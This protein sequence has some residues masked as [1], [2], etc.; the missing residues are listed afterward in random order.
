MRT[1]RLLGLVV[2]T[3]LFLPIL[4]TLLAG[5]DCTFDQENKDQFFGEFALKQIQCM[6]SEHLPI[7]S[8]GIIMSVMLLAIS[9]PF[10]LLHFEH[11]PL[12][13]TPTAKTNGRISFIFCL[14]KCVL[15]VLWKF[16]YNHGV[17]EHGS[18]NAIITTGYT[19]LMS[20]TMA[21]MMIKT[22]P[23][24]QAS[25][26]HSRFSIYFTATL[27]NLGAFVYSIASFFSSASDAKPLCIYLMASFVP[28]FVI[29][30][31]VSALV[32]KRIAKNVEK[33]YESFAAL[34]ESNG[35]QLKA[36]VYDNW[37]DVEIVGRSLTK[38]TRDRLT[39]IDFSAD[40]D[41]FNTRFDRGIKEWPDNHLVL[42]AYGLYL[43]H[44]NDFEFRESLKTSPKA[45]Q[46]L[47]LLIQTVVRKLKHLKRNKPY[48]DVQFV[49]VYLDRLMA[50]H[51]LSSSNSEDSKMDV[52]AYAEFK[53]KEKQAFSCHKMAISNINQAWSLIASKDYSNTQL[54]KVCT[55]LYN[56]TEIANRAYSELVRKFPSN[57]KL[58]KGYARFLIQVGHQPY[59][60]KNLVLQINAMEEATR[61]DE[62]AFIAKM[63]KKGGASTNGNNKVIQRT[64][65]FQSEG[66]GSGGD[67]KSDV[68]GS[69][70]NATSVELAQENMLKGVKSRITDKLRK[71]LR[72]LDLNNILISVVAMGTISLNFALVAALIYRITIDITYFQELHGREYYISDEVYSARKMYQALK[73]N[74]SVSY[75]FYR[76]R[77][78]SAFDSLAEINEFLLAERDKKDLEYSQEYLERIYNITIALYPASEEN[79]IVM[80]SL[81]DFVDMYLASGLVFVNFDYNEY[82]QKRPWNWL[83]TN[84]NF[85]Y[86]MDNFHSAGDLFEHSKNVFIAGASK[87]SS[88]GADT[89][90]I[91]LTVLQLAVVLL[92]LFV[93]DYIVSKFHKKQDQSLSLMRFIPH[94]QVKEITEQFEN[95]GMNDGDSDD[96]DDAA[97]NALDMAENQEL[98][99]FEGRN[100]YRLRYSI[101]FAIL[102]SLSAAT[103]V[104]NKTAIRYLGQKLAV[105]DTYGDAK[106]SGSRTV[107]VLE[108]YLEND[109]KVWGNEENIRVYLRQMITHM[110]NIKEH[111]VQGDQSFDP[112]GYGYVDQTDDIK[113]ITNQPNCLPMNE[114]MCQDL[115]R[116]NSTV[117]FD[118]EMVGAG[119]EALFAQVMNR[120]V[121]IKEQAKVTFKPD[122]LVVQFL[123]MV[124]KYDYPDGFDKVA[125]LLMVTALEHS[126]STQTTEIVFLV[127]TLSFIS[128]SYFIVFVLMAYELRQQLQQVA[129]LFLF[130][131]QTV[132]KAVPELSA[133]VQTGEIDAETEKKIQLIATR[134]SGM[135][136]RAEI[137]AAKQDAKADADQPKAAQGGFFKNVF[138]SSTSKSDDKKPIKENAQIE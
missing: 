62:D 125:K 35:K 81:Y 17:I 14:M 2:S 27:L 98:G 13:K 44:L 49:L 59:R 40:W 7:F 4:D 18:I 128:L 113:A 89:L 20:L 127:V 101:F 38:Y 46:E 15:V 56:N 23:Y 74:D 34:T 88:S 45:K 76:K 39:Y 55:R 65:S 66:S 118:E 10:H 85:R 121:A 130:L 50:E 37:A 53:K 91:A 100:G 72:V 63:D 123:N 104:Y 138:S 131:P 33:T 99:I 12:L 112:P 54:L 58:L 107:T 6:G 105:L 111:L 108:E 70:S 106:S 19:T 92:N 5:V 32:Y 73:I 43:I 3:S 68:S 21:I 61:Q 136:R 78:D 80:G 134:K 30:Y 25:I 41:A 31:F 22:F 120:L 87:N 82:P 8:L 28:F 84:N 129:N 93:V 94:S 16:V 96:D 109:E 57:L 137:A 24:F 117:K 29:G 52:A 97:I 135:S 102:V 47:P 126:Q 122:P 69:S 124:M 26:N 115:G 36:T 132:I 79:G 110:E 77:I 51:A 116:Y 133:Y 90:T 71:M 48:W 119:L 9:I 103:V 64:K 11:N 67:K 83:D 1:L 95:D 86:I 42:I 60:A 114:T 75:E